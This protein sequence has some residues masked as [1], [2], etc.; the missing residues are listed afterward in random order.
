VN[1]SGQLTE[2]GTCM[3]LGPNAALYI[4][5]NYNSPLMDFGPLII[6]G[7]QNQ[8]N[9]ACTFLARMQPGLLSISGDSLICGNGTIWLNASPFI[10]T[11]PSSLRWSTGATT[12]SI[13][14]TQPGTYTLTATFTGGY[15]LSAAFRVRASNVPVLPAFTLGSDTTLCAGQVLLRAPISAP[16]VVYRW[17]D[18]STGPSLLVREAGTYSLQISTSCSSQRASRRIDYAKCLLAIPNVITPN[19]D[20]HNDVFVAQNLPAGDWALTL[21][22]RWGKQVYSTSAYRHDWGSDAAPGQYYYLLRQAGTNTTYKGWL[23]VIR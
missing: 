6:Q 16:G 20:Q 7:V 14:V 17:S 18:G 13:S 22:N 5:G 3:T 21:Y 23:E 11:S 15:T 10:N 1:P 9:N 4:A 8:D 2:M 12:P 19:N